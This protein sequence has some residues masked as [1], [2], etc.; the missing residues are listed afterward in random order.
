MRKINQ[1]GLDLIKS[2]ETLQ[3]EPYQ[4]KA[5]RKGV[6][7]VGYG[8]VVTG[9]EHEEVA[10]AI[11]SGKITE[12]M[13][14]EILEDDIYDAIYAIYAITT[15]DKIDALTQDQF[16]AIVSLTFNIGRSNWQISAIRQTIMYG[17]PNDA[18]HGFKS[19]IK[20]NGTVARG[21][22]RRRAAEAA[23]YRGDY[24]EMKFHLDNIDIDR[25]E[26]YLDLES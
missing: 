17:N 6:I 16:D 7:T 24:L 8:H 20:A 19:F 23:L 14:T 25:A 15:K 4:G 9:Q 18:Y 26:T 12:K 22:I 5:D 21:L 10:Q 13:A 2:F 3:L 11:K 1:T